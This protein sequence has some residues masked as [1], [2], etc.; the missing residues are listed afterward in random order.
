MKTRAILLA[1]L[2]LIAGAPAAAAH[3][4]KECLVSIV[5]LNSSTDAVRRL[6]TA[7]V[8]G[9]LLGAPPKQLSNLK[10][11]LGIAEDRKK[12]ALPNIVL[13]CAP[14]RSHPLPGCDGTLDPDYDSYDT[15]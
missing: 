3:M 7:W 5:K 15:E 6:N 13:C 8:I 9:Q 10:E 12:A 4:T 2:V 1:A 14:G 11:Q